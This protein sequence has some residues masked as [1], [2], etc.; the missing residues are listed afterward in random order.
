M[1]S[2]FATDAFNFAALTTAINILPNRYGLI[3]KMNL[4]P[5]RGVP[6][7]KVKIEE[8]H[9]LLKL[10]PTTPKGSPGLLAARGKRKV[11]EFTIPHIPYD[12]VVLPEEAQDNRS[13]GYGNKLTSTADLLAQYLQAMRDNHSITLEHLRMGALKGEI[14][15]A[16]GSTIYDLFTEFNITA[17][18]IN[19]ELSNATTDVKAICLELKRH[20]EDNLSN[21][22]ADSITCLVSP[23]FYDAL[24]GHPVVKSA[25]DR[26]QNGEA[27]R[28][29]MRD[30]FPFGGILWREYRAKADTPEGATRRFIAANEG[31]AFPT[32]TSYFETYF[33]PGDFSDTVNQPGIEI[34]A[35][36]ED[37]KFRRGADLHTQSNPLPICVRPSILVKVTKS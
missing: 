6:T 20:I 15:D 11:R 3:Q 24:T 5:G 33:G 25:Y 4:M 19:F 7:T 32:G 16:D 21:Q 18:I 12:D 36:I 9:G 14:L 13:F 17:K 26:W 8:Y 1:G 10:L 30:G 31:H 34:Y 37:R 29:D 28:A 22:I 23:E 2:L 35:R 27:H